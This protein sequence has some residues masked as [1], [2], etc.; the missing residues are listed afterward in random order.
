M[1]TVIDYSQ[2]PEPLLNC[3]Q[4]QLAQSVT[5]AIPRTAPSETDLAFFC[6]MLVKPT[7][8]HAILTH[9]IFLFLDYHYCFSRYFQAGVSIGCT[10]QSIKSINPLAFTGVPRRPQASCKGIRSPDLK[11]GF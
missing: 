7:N 1:V 8:S 10:P 9:L 5:K 6:K 2:E 4:A 11:N 3:F